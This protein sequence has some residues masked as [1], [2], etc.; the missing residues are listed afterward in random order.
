MGIPHPSLSFNTNTVMAIVLSLVLLYG[1]LLG[2]QKLKT[3]ALSAFVGLVMVLTF[4]DGLMNLL[5]KSNINLGGHLSLSLIKLVLFVI[6]VIILEFGH[7]EKGK[8]RGGITMTLI[9]AVLTAALLIS[10]V[11]SF[12]ASDTA[13]MVIHQS[14][15]A[16]WIYTF[17]L[18]WL[19]AVPIAV[20]GE[21][22]IPS[23]SH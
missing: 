1:L 21:N 9:L 11:I 4:A 17:R 19:I 7:K 2:Q 8:S 20:V 22:F 13:Q 5:H 3:F 16:D 18:V 10:S 6:P 23:K 12:L 15:L 14:I